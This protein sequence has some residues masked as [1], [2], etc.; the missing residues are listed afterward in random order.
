MMTN[1]QDRGSTVVSSSGLPPE[2]IRSLKNTADGRERSKKVRN[3]VS[4]FGRSDTLTFNKNK[5]KQRE[6]ANFKKN[7]LLNS[8][9]PQASSLEPVTS[10]KNLPTNANLGEVVKTKTDRCTLCRA[11]F[12]SVLSPLSAK[13]YNCTKCGLS[14]CDSCSD[15]RI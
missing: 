13:H 4:F 2:P 5:D 3:S 10:L 11:Q 6:S 15:H 7:T 14:V 9:A 1:S 12:R 8:L